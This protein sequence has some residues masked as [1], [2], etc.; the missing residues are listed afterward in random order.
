MKSLAETGLGEIHKLST[1][2]ETF[3]L[4]LILGLEIE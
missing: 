2:A 1:N 4:A 3:L